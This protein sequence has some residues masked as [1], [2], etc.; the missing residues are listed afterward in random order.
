M[1]ALRI[2]FLIIFTLHPCLYCNDA[3]LNTIISVYAGAF[4]KYIHDL[5]IKYPYDEYTAY[6]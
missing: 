6:I 1:T 3:P 4:I 2:N 5:L